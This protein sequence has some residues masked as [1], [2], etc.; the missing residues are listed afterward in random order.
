MRPSPWGVLAAAAVLIAAAQPGGPAGRGAAPAVEPVASGR[1]APSTASLLRPASRWD[2][3]RALRYSD[4][5]R[6]ASTTLDLY[7][8]D[9]GAEQ[10]PL[11]IWIHGGGWIA[12]SKDK[13][14]APRDA[15]MM[16]RGFAVACMNYRLTTEARWP[17]QIVDV[18][19]AIRA[20]RADAARYRLYDEI[21]VW[22]ASAGGHL[23][24]MAGAAADV[25]EWEVGAN[26]EVSSRVQA[27]VDDFGPTNLL[28]DV[29]D[30]SAPPIQAA[31]DALITALLG[32]SRHRD[33]ARAR[34][35]SPVYWVDGD[36]PPFVIWHGTQDKAVPLSQSRELRDQLRSVGVPVE[37]TIAKGAGHGGPQ[38]YGPERIRAMADFFAT[39]LRPDP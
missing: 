5:G 13:D 4:A 22:G 16:S 1:T 29:R 18:K 14:C 3:F 2:T 7:V 17:A 8:P 39:T 20:L 15:D 28:S 23:A 37:L 9:N 11:I 10:V 24:A 25:P 36:E 31:Q 32:G 12:G 19:A 38:A 33:P 30:Q 26:L 35:A 27:V 21:G 6:G 34:S